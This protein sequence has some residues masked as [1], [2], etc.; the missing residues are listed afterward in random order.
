MT[1]R[2]DKLLAIMAT[3]ATLQAAA[4]R[5]RQPAAAVRAFATIGELRREAARDADTAALL[6]RLLSVC[7]ALTRPLRAARRRQTAGLRG[8]QSVRPRRAVPV[9]DAEI[10][11]AVAKYPTRT[12][13]ARRLGV[14]PSTLRRWLDRA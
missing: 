13:A 4:G 8:W 3:A 12:D 10:A 6:W 1:P 11:A 7:L 14:D 2:A 5:P 9:T